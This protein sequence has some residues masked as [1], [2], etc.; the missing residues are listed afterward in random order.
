MTTS[1]ETPRDEL[2]RQALE[3][4]E[5]RAEF[6]MHLAAYLLVNA[7]LVTIWF[8]VADGGL[9]WPIF[10]MLGWGIGLML[11]AMETFR[12]PVTED[13]IAREMQRLTPDR[14]SEDHAR[15]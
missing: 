3:R 5:K 13:R 6:R 1:T 11:H 9:F 15:Q 14:S 2:R 7:V 10:P 12:L 4:L 8:V